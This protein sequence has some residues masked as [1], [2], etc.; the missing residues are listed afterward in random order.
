MG[1]RWGP[2]QEAGCGRRG[3]GVDGG[4]GFAAPKLAFESGSL[5]AAMFK[6]DGV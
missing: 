1:R 3:G 2:P 5:K 4:D 6:T